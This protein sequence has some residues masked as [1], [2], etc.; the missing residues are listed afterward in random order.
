MSRRIGVRGTC[1]GR[2]SIEINGWVLG[3]LVLIAFPIMLLFPTDK[4]EHED[5][6]KIYWFT[7]D[8]TP[9]ENS[10]VCQY[11][12]ECGER[13]KYSYFRGTLVDQ[14]YLTAIT[15]HSDSNEIIPG[16][17]YTIT[18]IVPSGYNGVMKLKCRVENEK[19]I[20]DFSAKFR[21]EFREQLQSIG[22]G[23]EITFRGRFY[24]QGCGFTDAELI[25]VSEGA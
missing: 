10:N 20:V 23:R 24:D 3:L 5:L 17:Y 22:S 2:R 18:A 1:I 12:K 4:C 14:S 9:W 6:V 11:C 13:A 16:E 25:E 19:F 8:D 7:A 21:E 15:E